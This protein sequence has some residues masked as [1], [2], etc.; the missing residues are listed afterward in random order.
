MPEGIVLR[1]G[2]LYGPGS[3]EGFV[4]MIRAHKVPIIGDGGGVWSWLHLYDAAAATVAALER[5]APGVYNIVD[6]DP[7]P[8]RDWLPY[9]A[10]VVGAERPRH[11]PVWVGYLAAGSVGVRMMTESRGASN[12]KAKRE[13]DWSP[14][15]RSW[16]DG[17]RGALMDTVPAATT[18]APRPESGAP[19]RP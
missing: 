15:W 14:V 8:V 6:D 1:Y 11:V 3:S 5:A 18:I 16:R 7:A 19:A 10:E 12:A 2:N 4:E 17:F 9:L 13:L